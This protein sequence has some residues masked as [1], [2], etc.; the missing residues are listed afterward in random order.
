MQPSGEFCACG[1]SLLSGATETYF[2]AGITP[3]YPLSGVLRVTFSK[4]DHFNYTDKGGQTYSFHCSTGEN[5]VDCAEGSGLYYN[6]DLTDGHSIFVGRS[7]WEEEDP[8]NWRLS[9]GDALF[10]VPRDVAKAG[11]TFHLRWKETD[12]GGRLLCVQEPGT[13]SIP[14]GKP[15]KDYAKD[16][17]MESCYFAIANVAN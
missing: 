1:L 14:D 5:S 7:Q 2:G 9:G 10:D 8:M 3:P 13:E 6:L 12:L 4:D 15:R 17:R 16:H 11:F